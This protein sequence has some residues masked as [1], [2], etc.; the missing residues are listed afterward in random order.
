MVVEIILP[1]F[2]E[3]RIR[4]KTLIEEYSVVSE[5]PLLTA[6]TIAYCESMSLGTGI[7]LYGCRN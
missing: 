4:V 2:T 1:K 7:T 6:A 3:I 5:S